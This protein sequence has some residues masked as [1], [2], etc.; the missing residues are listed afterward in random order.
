M[1]C[2]HCGCKCVCIDPLIHVAIVLCSVS[3]LTIAMLLTLP[4]WKK[5]TQKDESLAGPS[6][7]RGERMKE[8]HERNGHKTGDLPQ[9]H[10]HR[11]ILVFTSPYIFHKAIS[12][13][14]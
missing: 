3:F 6:K 13:Q 7:G 5:V 11:H 10:T 4:L 8:R 2:V 14:S 12:H 1:L 9:P